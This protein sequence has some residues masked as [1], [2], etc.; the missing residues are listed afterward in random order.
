MNIIRSR[1]KILALFF[2]VALLMCCNKMIHEDNSLCGVDIMFK[3]DLNTL[4]IDKF[5][6]DVHKIHLYVFDKDGRLVAE[7]IDEGSFGT[8]YRMHLNLP[9]GV[10]DFIVWGGI[11]ID[12]ETP[13]ER[14][15]TIMSNRRLNLRAPNN[16]VETFPDDLYYGSSMKVEIKVLDNQVVL[17]PMMKD[18]K[19]VRVVF[20]GLP[21]LISSGVA[22]GGGSFV[23]WIEAENGDYGFDNLP[24]GTR[25]LR[26]LP[27]ENIQEAL[28]EMLYDFVTLRLFNNDNSKLILEYVYLD[29]TRERLLDISL[30]E[31]IKK[32]Y[33]IPNNVSNAPDFNE[34]NYWRDFFIVADE[35]V[36]KYEI[37]LTLGGFII[38]P[39]NW[40]QVPGGGGVIG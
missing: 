24:I 22:N 14:A 34:A 8:D 18:T 28:N 35:F 39:A 12:G 19:H 13:Y 21:G 26:Y 7:V 27:K 11:G 4:G 31:E 1:K 32:H 30:T 3:Y 16:T 2:T 36:L 23:C 9:A 40:N 10:Y 17:I 20:D 6:D 15:G 33:P 29:G 37:K 25:R 5:P 38:N